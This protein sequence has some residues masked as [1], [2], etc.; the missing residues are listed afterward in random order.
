MGKK[1]SEESVMMGIA[2]EI[3]CHGEPIEIL[4]LADLHIGDPHCNLDL[5]HNLIDS[6]KNNRNRYCVLLGDLCNTALIGS[7]SDSYGETMTPREELKYCKEL[8]AP[9]RDK[10]LALVPGNHEWRASRMAGLDITYE[11]ADKLDLLDVYSDTS[12]LVFLKFGCSARHSRPV[13]YSLYI[14][15]GHG[16][17]RKIGGKANALKD[18]SDI[19]DV[20]CYVVGHTHACQVFFDST[21]R[22]VPQKFRALRCDRAYV[23]VASALDYGGY[24][25]RGGYTPSSNRYPLITLHNDEH[26]VDAGMTRLF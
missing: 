12:A 15:H 2:H 20:D 21:Y 13:V 14:N 11:L 7:K 16:G 4:P 3:D 24:G 26:I 5:V 6:I 9:I 17:G 23:N 22:V 10:I 19:V 18:H 25:K 8:F 1:K